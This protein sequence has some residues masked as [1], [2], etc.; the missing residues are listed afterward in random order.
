MKKSDYIRFKK[1]LERLKS[2]LNFFVE[3]HV[4]ALF[5]FV[6]MAM[7]MKCEQSTFRQFIRYYFIPKRDTINANFCY[8]YKKKMVP[9]IYN[10][11]RRR[12]ELTLDEIVKYLYENKRHLVKKIALVYLILNFL[13]KAELII[14][15]DENKWK[16]NPYPS[17]IKEMFKKRYKL[18]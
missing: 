5:S 18:K 14:K 10:L 15:V 1:K 12:K 17:K 3:Y 9:V 7:I 13:E 4:Y 2:Q 16:I 8:G 6:E 11:F